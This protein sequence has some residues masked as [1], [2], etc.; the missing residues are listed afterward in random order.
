M[1]SILVL[2]KTTHHCSLSSY[3]KHSPRL[4][5]VCLADPA[6]GRRRRHRHRQRHG[7]KRKVCTRFACG[8]EA[9]CQQDG[10]S[11]RCICPRD[12]SEVEPGQPCRYQLPTVATVTDAPVT[13]LT[14]F[15]TPPGGSS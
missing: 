5:C 4:V 15:T 7:R 10:D 6:D 13:M 9:A 8:P 2:L 1:A 11:F 12:L 14:A 3:E